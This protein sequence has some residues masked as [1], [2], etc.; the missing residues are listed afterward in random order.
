MVGRERRL[1][2]RA[3][4]GD[5]RAASELL[6][7]S[8]EKVFN[9][10]RRLCGSVADAEDLTQE[11]FAKVWSSLSEY[12]GRCAFSTW[13]HRIA[14]HVYVDWRRG[15]EPP[16]PQTD[17][18]WQERTDLNPGPFKCAED[19]QLAE[20]LYGLVDRLS[21]DKKQIICLHFYQGLSLR[22]TAYVL[23][24]APSTVKYGFRRIMKYLRSELNEV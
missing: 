8:Y 20:R 24:Q 10:L 7:L 16:V 1:C 21:E 11:T 22:E 9:Y 19:K 4:E 5:E 17:A 12:R 2:R 18:W 3:K 15:K 23:N 14:Y 13:V 6:R